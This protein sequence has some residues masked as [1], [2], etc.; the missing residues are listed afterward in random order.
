VAPKIEIIPM[1]EQD[2]E[3]LRD[4]RLEMLADTPTAYLE[5]LTAAR[6]LDD[7]QWRERAR[8]AGNPG[9]VGLVAVDRAADGSADRSAAD[10]S[11]GRF[12]GT[13]SAYTDAGTTW[14]VAVYVAPGY[15]ATGVADL[16]LDGVESWARDRG[17]AR[18]SL[19]VHE[20]N[21]RA[22]RF[23]LRRGY[24]FTGRERPYELNAAQTEREM[25]RTLR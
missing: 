14:L 11:A 21:E 22:Q 15:Q 2:W 20:A 12:V 10:R 17:I 6:S 9:S 13:M 18:L 23:Y 3:R 4:L 5:P 8:R 19:E 24:T 7:A 25:T 16:L 1:A